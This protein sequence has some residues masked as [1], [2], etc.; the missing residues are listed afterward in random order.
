MR[1]EPRNSERSAPPTEQTRGLSLRAVKMAAG[2]SG[3]N[4]GRTTARKR[5]HTGPYIFW[6]NG[7]RLRTCARMRT[8]RG[9]GRET[10]SEPDSKRG[11]T[12]EAIAEALFEARVTELQDRRWG[13]VGALHRWSRTEAPSTP[14]S[15]TRRPLSTRPSTEP[16]RDLEFDQSRGG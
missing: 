16:D 7:R 11:T 5:K 8:G 9:R 14:S 2:A 1:F 4:P 3:H 15:S 13:R 10:L 6:R 12:D